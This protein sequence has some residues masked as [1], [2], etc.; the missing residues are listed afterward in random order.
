[1]LLVARDKGVVAIYRQTNVAG[2]GEMP[3]Y[4]WTE[5]YRS[6][7]DERTVGVNRYYTAMAQNDQI[8]MLIEVSYTQAL[9]TATDK[10]GIDRRYFG[11]DEI[12][13]DNNIYFRIT[14][15]QQA[16]GDD[17][18]PVTLLSLERV[19]GLE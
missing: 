11:M 4:N 12:Q 15:I 8:D 3:T 5:I 18:L 17:H 6:Y 1:M 9:S 2:V 7:Y 14:M 19:D 10:A 16:D 13:G